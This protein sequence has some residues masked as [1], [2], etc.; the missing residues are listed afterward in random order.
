ME[1]DYLK[2]VSGHTLNAFKEIEKAFSLGVKSIV[3]DSGCGTGYS[4]V[5]LAKRFPESLVIGL[6]KS[7][8]RLRK[9]KHKERFDN[10]LFVRADQFDFWHLLV[11]AGWPVVKH[12]MYYPNPWPKKAH[13]KRRIHGHPA[14]VELPKLTKNI[15][16]RSNWL[17]YVQEFAA[18][19][20]ILTH[21]DLILEKIEPVQPV[22][23]FEKKFKES[24]HQLYRLVTRSNN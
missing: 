20:Q 1:H 6:D 22:S 2:P 17:T 13:I 15:E 19:W 11:K 24:G 12:C 18:A 9:T 16:V 7:D 21:E 5:I 10:V 4:T 14:F 3:L 23:L 8:I